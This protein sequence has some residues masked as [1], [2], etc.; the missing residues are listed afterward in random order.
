MIDVRLSFDGV[1]VLT[2]RMTGLCA[3]ITWTWNTLL[4]LVV[5]WLWYLKLKI[6]FYLNRVNMK[7]WKVSENGTFA[8]LKKWNMAKNCKKIKFFQPKFDG[9]S[10]MFHFKKIKI[11]HIS[12]RHF[13]QKLCAIKF[14]PLTAFSFCKKSLNRKFYR[15]RSFKY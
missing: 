7:H 6:G 5:N 14:P 15:I 2:G 3:Q 12:I 1:Y 13:N 11:K 4:Y 10:E 8:T 9:F